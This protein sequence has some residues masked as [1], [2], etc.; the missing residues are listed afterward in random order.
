MIAHGK[1]LHLGRFTLA[2]STALLI[3]LATA[4]AHDNHT[5]DGSNAPSATLVGG[6]VPRYFQVSHNY[7]N[8]FNGITHL[9]YELPMESDVQVF[10][11]NVL[12]LRV[13][14]L[15]SRTQ[16]AGSYEMH[17]N[18]R[19]DRGDVVPSGPYFVI[20]RTNDNYTVRKVM[21]IK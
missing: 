8:P 19:N 4:R 11:Y 12:G 16:Q 21:M 7:P 14:R 3:C 17:W 10:V 15:M 9:N 18:G 1:R 13:R 5:P 6:I 20:F 2:I